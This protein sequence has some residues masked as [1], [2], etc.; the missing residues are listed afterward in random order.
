MTIIAAVVAV[1]VIMVGGGIL[2]IGIVMSGR[3]IRPRLACLRRTEPSIKR[4]SP[5]GHG[6]GQTEH[7]DDDEPKPRHG[8]HYSSFRLMITNCPLREHQV[9]TF[10]AGVFSFL[11]EQIRT[12][13]TSLESLLSQ[14]A[15]RRKLAT[16]LNAR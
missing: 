2:A 3:R 14:S 10:Q 13:A 11:S 9:R 15:L 16:L 8:P 4:G 6:N 7:Q 1:S 5:P 12:L